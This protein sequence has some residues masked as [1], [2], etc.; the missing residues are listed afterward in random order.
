ML[1]ADNISVIDDY[2]EAW[3][4][5]SENTFADT[6]LKQS[7]N[8][9]VEAIIALHPFAA[10]PL[11]AWHLENFIELANRLQKIYRVRILVLGG[12][13]DTD[14]ALTIQKNVS[15]APIMAVGTTSLRE[16][17]AL[18]SRCSLLICNDSGI[19]HLAAAMQIPL[20]ALFGPQSPVKFGPWGEK[21]RVIYERFPCSP[22]KQKFFQECEPS[23]RSSPKCLETIS[24]EK[25]L[26]E[27]ASFKQNY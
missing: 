16:S 25:V 27:V 7:G 23:H 18:L 26:E 8:G 9:Q 3:L 24:I 12:K 13:R 15:P 6:F 22:C 14:A 11:R 4:T 5:E 20:V 1:R 19:M 17:M 2:L 10:N 21:C